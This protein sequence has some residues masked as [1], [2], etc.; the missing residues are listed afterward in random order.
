M[1]KER[2]KDTH[3]TRKTKDKHVHAAA[4]LIFFDSFLIFLIPFF[5]APVFFCLPVS[6]DFAKNVELPRFLDVDQVK[7]TVTFTDFL[8]GNGRNCAYYRVLHGRAPWCVDEWGQRESLDVVKTP[9]VYAHY[10]LVTT[11][12][13]T[14]PATSISAA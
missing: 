4:I 1:S 8:L 11:V 13:I 14:I 6:R 10:F 5:D 2:S 12:E 3:R 9:L 7:R